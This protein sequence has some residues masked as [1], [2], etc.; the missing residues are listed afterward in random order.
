VGDSRGPRGRGDRCL[1]VAKKTSDVN[2]A[3]GAAVRSA[4]I[5]RGYSQGGFAAHAGMDLSDYRAIERGEF[6]V[7]YSTVVTI[8]DALEVPAHE[9]IQRGEK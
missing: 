6:N 3:F 5:E 9:L 2:V 4:R 1:V 8:A 7:R